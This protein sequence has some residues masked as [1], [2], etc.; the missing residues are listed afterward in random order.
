VTV[1][2][3]WDAAAAAYVPMIQAGPAG[4]KGPVG[5]PGIG[6]PPGGLTGDFLLA[7]SAIKGEAHW[8]VPA[9]VPKG[10]RAFGSGPPATVM[11]PGSFLTVTADIEAGRLYLISAYCRATIKV[12]HTGTGQYSGGYYFLNTPDAASTRVYWEPHMLINDPCYTSWAKVW[13][14]TV[15]G[16]HPFVIGMNTN[17]GPAGGLGEVTAN[18]CELAITDMGLGI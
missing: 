3:Y 18:S 16:S 10:I 15:S 2:K 1:A 8:E 13:K 7:D 17:S 5:D 9:W 14:S 6:L 4:A 12:G 11:P